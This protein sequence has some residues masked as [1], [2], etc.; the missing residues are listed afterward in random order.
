MSDLHTTQ[1]NLSGLLEVLGKNLYSTP[2][3]VVREL[4]QNAHDAC[5]RR[6]IEDPGDHK[7]EIHIQTDASKKTLTIIDNGAGLTEQEIVDYLATIGSGYTGILREQTHT[8]DMIGCFGLGFL[9]AYV[10]SDKVKMWTSSYKDPSKG[11]Y[12]LSTGGKAY[13]VQACEKDQIGSKIVLKLAD[14]FVDLSDSGL[15]QELLTQYCCL[16]PYKIFLNQQSEAVNAVNIPWR[17]ADDAPAVR[18]KKQYLD[19]AQVFEQRFEPLCHI[20]LHGDEHCKVN[21]LLWVQDSSTY[22]SNDNRSVTVFVRNMYITDQARELL[23]DWAGFVGCMVESVSLTP[24]ASREDIQ[25]DREFDRLRS[26]IAETLVLGLK[27]LA[28]K[29]PETWRRILSRHNEGLLGAAVSEDRLFSVLRDEL[30]LPTSDGELTIKEI[31]KRGNRKIH[32]SLED[33]GGFE[34][35]LCRSLKIPIVKGYRYAVLP[36]CRIH[37]EQTGESKLLLLGTKDGSEALFENVDLGSEQE[38]VLAELLVGENEKL[39]PSRFEPDFLPMVIIDNEDALLKQRIESD[40][41]DKRI[42]T[43]ALGLAR[44]YTE[45]INEDCSAYV[46][47]NLNSPLIQKLLTNTPKRETLAGVLR[48]FTLI[49]S[50]GESFSGENTLAQELEQYNNNILALLDQPKVQ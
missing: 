24:T 27:Q 16:L 31:L 36:F 5:V 35:V 25:K 11:W 20:P 21:G 13:S 18:L 17:Q 50:G 28:I 3:V 32:V 33:K 23:P 39:M 26:L 47:I 8:E 9:T 40:E 14:E 4:I 43:S 10:V 41:A 15:L 29:E 44:M 46:Y 7:F 38:A 12:F 6:S 30:K 1:I 45:K 2:S 48:S 19:L 42:S 49:L 37:E 34:E 22:G